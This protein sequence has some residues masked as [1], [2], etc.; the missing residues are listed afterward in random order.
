MYMESYV[1]LKT[2]NRYCLYCLHSQRSGKCKY[3]LS[4][5]TYTVCRNCNE[6]T[7]A[8]YSCTVDAV[9]PQ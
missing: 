4:F 1:L 3:V 8:D 5:R 2:G 6:Y 7:I 9:R